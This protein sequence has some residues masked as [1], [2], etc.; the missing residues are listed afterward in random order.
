MCCLKIFALYGCV[1]LD[2]RPLV[3]LT[4]SGNASLPTSSP[5][6]DPAII[7]PFF[8]SSGSLSPAVVQY[9]I[10][11][12]PSAN[13]SLVGEILDDIE[14]VHTEPNRVRILRRIYVFTWLR[15]STSDGQVGYSSL[16]TCYFIYYCVLFQVF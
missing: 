16:N 13:D 3:N 8:P 10:I 7:C 4:L 5:A 9:A 11:R 14:E 1:S 6:S 15:A 2:G 12:D